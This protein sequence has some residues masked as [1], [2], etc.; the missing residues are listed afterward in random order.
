M[1]RAV[2]HEHG[3]RGAGALAL[4]AHDA[5]AAVGR[6]A[7]RLRAGHAAGLG[8]DLVGAPQRA[9]HVVAHADDVAADGPQVEH[10][11]EGGDPEDL[12]RLEPEVRGTRL[13]GVGRQTIT[14]DLNR[15]LIGSLM[16]AGWLTYF[17]LWPSR[18][19]RDGE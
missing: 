16:L 10:R 1:E 13:E 4:D 19:A 9:R 17:Y 2:E 14:S 18:K 12:D 8:E 7:A 15:Y 11:V 3:R 5:E 6:D